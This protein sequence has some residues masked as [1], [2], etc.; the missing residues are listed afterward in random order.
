MSRTE[1]EFGKAVAIRLIEMEIT[2][3][4]LARR[5]GCSRTYLSR[6]LSGDRSGARNYIEKICIE[7]GLDMEP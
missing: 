1:T 4:E 2:Q 3:A 6:I 5:I 7:L